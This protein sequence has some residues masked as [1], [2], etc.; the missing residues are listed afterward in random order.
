MRRI[1][2]TLSAALHEIRCAECRVT[3]SSWIARLAGVGGMSPKVCICARVLMVG[4]EARSC[5][6]HGWSG[7]QTRPADAILG[8]NS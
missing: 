7:E 5:A 2:I 6:V 1:R 4:E 3:W 8:E